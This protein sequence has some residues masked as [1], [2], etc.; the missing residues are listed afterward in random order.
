MRAAGGELTFTRLE[1]L[2]AARAAGAPSVGAA[3][4][5]LRRLGRL[6]VVASPR[7][8]FFVSVPPRYRADGCPPVEWFIDSLMRH[9]GR[10][11][12]VGLESA[13]ALHGASCDPPR[14]LQVITDGFVRDIEVG[15]ARI[16]FHDTRRL[17]GAARERRSVG[18]AMMLVATPETTAFDLLGF[19][20][21]SGDWLRR[22][23]LI[24]EIADG[25]DPEA[26]ASGALRVARSQVQR[27]GWLLELT[28]RLE[29]ADALAGTLQGRR[30]RP[31]PLV[32]G[33]AAD[34]GTVHPRW[35]V[36]ANVA[37]PGVAA[38]GE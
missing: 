14:A 12:Y 34:H 8:G 20:D 32:P 33:R 13:A 11:Y 26:L 9:L 25:L 1:A 16:H 27:L 23:Q 17:E 24:A 6:G 36:V 21:E 37:L 18:G 38:A 10:S 5:A 31:T 4:A 28:E 2:A 3:E 7:Q 19:P 22:A 29:L 30:L 35:R 15:C